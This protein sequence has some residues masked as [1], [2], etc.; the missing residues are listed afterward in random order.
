MKKFICILTAKDFKERSRSHTG[1][2]QGGSKTR[3][4]SEIKRCTDDTEC[5]WHCYLLPSSKISGQAS[6]REGDPKS[7]PWRT[8]LLSSR[9]EGTPRQLLPVLVLDRWGQQRTRLQEAVEETFQRQAEAGPSRRH[10]TKKLGWQAD[11]QI[12]GKTE[13]AG[14]G[15]TAR[16]WQEGT[17]PRCC[18]RRQ[19]GS[20]VLGSLWQALK[21]HLP[22]KGETAR[23]IKIRNKKI[24]T[25]V[26]S[27]RLTVLSL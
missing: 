4:E 21:E 26:P 3:S 24:L 15:T 23:S 18:P 27:L 9:T 12:M 22:F 1:K 8:G 2:R 17:T 25:L 7:S 6:W 19:N 14:L 16:D 10:Q 20:E 13:P 11:R 5:L